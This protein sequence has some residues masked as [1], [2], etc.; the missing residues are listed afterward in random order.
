V[1]RG[2]TLLFALLAVA[3]AAAPAT[4]AAATK[5]RFGKTVVLQP[6]SGNVLVKAPGKKATRLKRRT[7]VPLGSAI[8]TTNGKVKLTSALPSGK[9]QSAKFNGGAFVVTQPKG[10][11]G[12]TDLR[13]TGGNL[14]GCDAGAG[15]AQR[16]GRRLFGNGRGRFRTR[17]RN[18]SATVR[19]TTW[20]T[21][22]D[23]S[24]TAITSVEGEVDTR[25]AGARL[26]RILDPGES[27]TY[28]CNVPGNQPAPGSYCLLTISDPVHGLLGMGIIAVTDETQYRLCLTYPNGAED[29]GDL[30]LSEPMEFGFRQS[31]AACFVPL[32]GRY[33]IRW[34]LAGQQL[35]PEMRSAVIEPNSSG[36]YFCAQQ[37][38]PAPEAASRAPGR[39]AEATRTGSRAQDVRALGRAALPAAP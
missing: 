12:L 28:Y 10:G 38:E 5:P 3:V 34:S 21:E 29:C 35:F 2:P 23:C 27:A 6:V 36:Q 31:V 1:F 14:D 25:A 32:R 17:G 9:R 18:S 4:A 16:R 30:P 7:A 15:A 19:G 8:S 11:R 20:V 22:D 33:L 39:A 26:E 24:G 37:T 13:L